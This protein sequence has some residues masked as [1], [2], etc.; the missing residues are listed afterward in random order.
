MPPIETFTSKVRE[1]LDADPEVMKTP[2]VL[3]IL[4][5]FHRDWQQDAQD[6]LHID[7]CADY[8]SLIL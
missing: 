4:E 5:Q 2:K 1:I 8:L 7:L 6:D 3:K